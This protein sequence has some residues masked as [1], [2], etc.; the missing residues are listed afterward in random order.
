[1]ALNKKYSFVCT[2]TV[3]VDCH[4]VVTSVV[5][6]WTESLHA[7]DVYMQIPGPAVLR[8]RTCFAGQPTL[9]RREIVFVHFHINSCR[10]L[11]ILLS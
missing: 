7:F 5:L 10:C 3:V 1:M 8:R 2:Y 4:L 6:D 9:R 11:T